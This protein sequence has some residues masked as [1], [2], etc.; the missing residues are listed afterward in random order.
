MERYLKLIRTNE[1]D[2]WEFARSKT[3]IRL[4]MEVKKDLERGNR[5]FVYKIIDETDFSFI[6]SNILNTNDLKEVIKSC[7]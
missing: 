1:S 4:R 7:I 3:E 2:A 5:V 6:C